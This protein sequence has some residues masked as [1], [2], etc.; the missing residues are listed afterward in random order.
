MAHCIFLS[1]L[2]CKHQGQWSGMVY[3]GG[4]MEESSNWIIKNI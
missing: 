2:I 4:W 3:I 1:N